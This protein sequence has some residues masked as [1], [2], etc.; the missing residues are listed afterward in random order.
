[1]N[2]HPD[3]MKKRPPERVADALE[4]I[5]EL[6]CKVL[7]ALLNPPGPTGQDVLNLNIR[8]IHGRS[9][10]KMALDPILLLDTEKIL[11]SV[12]P[13]KADGTPDDSVT[14]SWSSSDLSVGLEVQ[15]DSRS[16][17]ALTP[18]ETGAATITVSA[19]GYTTETVDISYK[20]GEPRSLNLSAGTPVSDAP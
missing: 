12:A 1:M 14:V 16:A 11:L 13:Q 20:P 19:P 10:A 2:W 3:K 5:K 8:E 4:E 9:N 15:A 6:L 7:H 18:G 17:F